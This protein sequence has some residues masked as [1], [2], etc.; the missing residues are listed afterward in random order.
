[1]L[2]EGIQPV[3]DTYFRAIAVRRHDRMLIALRSSADNFFSFGYA[4][5]LVSR[6]NAMLYCCRDKL[7]SVRAPSRSAQA[8]SLV[9]SEH[10]LVLRKRHRNVAGPS[11]VPSEHYLVLPELY[12]FA[13]RDDVKQGCVERTVEETA[14]W[15]SQ[16][17]HTTKP[18]EIPITARV[19]K[20]NGALYPGGKS[21]TIR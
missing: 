12:P 16:R 9:P 1:M 15:A 4:S 21:T 13:R 7:S 8:S 10:H 20:N 14:T 18:L 19:A 2:R 11:L 6:F 17:L 3:L 5:S